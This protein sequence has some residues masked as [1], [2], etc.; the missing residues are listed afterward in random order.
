VKTLLLF[1]VLAASAFAASDQENFAGA[2]R[3]AKNF[4]ASIDAGN[5]TGAKQHVYQTDHRT[6]NRGASKKVPI[7][8][9]HTRIQDR[10]KLGRLL[11]R[12]LEKKAVV[13]DAVHNLPSGKFVEFTYVVRYEKRPKETKET[14]VIKADNPQRWS[15]VQ[16]R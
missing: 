11:E 4:L 6:E 1:A 2:E 15:V 14:L 5:V 12:R 8:A 9:V 16:Y 10:E 13:T 7:V 3:V